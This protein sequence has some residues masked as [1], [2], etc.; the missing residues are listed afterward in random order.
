MLL[1]AN[2]V[3]NNEREEEEFQFKIF[4]WIAQ[5]FAGISA[6]E[7][8]PCHHECHEL[9]ITNRLINNFVSFC[10]FYKARDAF[11]VFYVSLTSIK[12]KFPLWLQVNTMKSK[13]LMRL[14]L[15]ISTVVQLSTYHSLH[16]AVTWSRHGLSSAS[17]Y[18]DDISTICD[19]I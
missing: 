6:V 14:L 17:R 3:Q 1:K 16:K 18:F 5:L 8:I 11:L 9:S 10:F 4:C 15:D 2:Y 7:I 19:F 12:N 13:L